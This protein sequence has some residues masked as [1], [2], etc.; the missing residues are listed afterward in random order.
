MGPW[1]K[2]THADEVVPVSRGPGRGWIMA[3]SGEPGKPLEVA[4]S[5]RPAEYHQADR[6]QTG[7]SFGASLESTPQTHGGSHGFTLVLACAWL[8]TKPCLH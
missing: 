4:D 3:A 7:P 2:L 1:P 8:A 6:P 5:C